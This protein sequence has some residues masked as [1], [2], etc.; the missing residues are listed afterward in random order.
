MTIKFWAAKGTYGC[1]SNFSKDPIEYGG[2]T[3]RTSEHLYQSLK[4][5][6]GVDRRAVI[7]CNTARCAADTGREETR[8][9]REDWDEIK[10]DVMCLAVSLKLMQNEYI[11]NLLMETEQ[12]DIIEDSPTDYYWGCGVDGTG[13][14]R[15]GEVFMLIRDLIKGG[16]DI[17]QI[18]NQC[19]I[20]S[21]RW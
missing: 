18:V 14:N 8:E 6:N 9:L 10:F 11:L 16:L 4:F 17:D 21:T 15:L 1:F 5:R 3:Y 2:V 12:Q 20:V 19:I 7:D 13:R